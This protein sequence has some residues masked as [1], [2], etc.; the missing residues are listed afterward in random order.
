ML[1]LPIIIIILLTIYIL[2][3][4]N[5]NNKEH[6]NEGTYHYLKYNHPLE[7]TRTNLD[8]RHRPLCKKD[9]RSNASGD[10]YCNDAPSFLKHDEHLYGSGYW[11]QTRH[12]SYFYPPYSTNLTPRHMYAPDWWHRKI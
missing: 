6:L 10:R 12:P 7:R 4:I 9:I 1:N 2:Y 5:D 8:Y 3:Q 11:V